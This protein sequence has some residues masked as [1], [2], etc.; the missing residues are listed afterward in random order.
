MITAASEAAKEQS[1]LMRKKDAEMLQAQTQKT[2]E[3]S[4]AAATVRVDFGT[5]KVST[6]Q[7]YE[8]NYMFSRCSSICLGGCLQHILK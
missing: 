8:C 7:T 2:I 4:Q 6:L 3:E 5:Y 1:E